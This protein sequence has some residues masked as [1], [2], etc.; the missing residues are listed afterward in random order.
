MTDAWDPEQYRRFADERAQPFR[1][2]VAMAV[3]LADGPM[4]RGVD[5]G[6]G[7]AELTQEAFDA[8]GVVERTGIDASE[9]MVAAS[10]R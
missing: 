1:D 9:A 7:D 2:L 5:L 8:F 6:C 10:G 3:P 4:S